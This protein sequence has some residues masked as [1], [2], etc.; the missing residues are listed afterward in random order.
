MIFSGIGVMRADLGA[1]V[2]IEKTFE[3]S[4]ENRRI[5]EAPIEAGGGEQQADFAVFE[6]QRRTAVEQAAVEL[7]RC[8]RD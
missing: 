2:G 7:A 1:F 6:R 4:A 8:L 5:D 3:Q